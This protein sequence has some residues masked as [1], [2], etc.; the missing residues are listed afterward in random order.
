MPTAIVTGST[1]GIGLG[2]ARALAEA[3]CNIVLN[4]FGEAKAIESERAQ[5]EK[6]FKVRTIFDPTDLAK[7]AAI[8]QMVETTTR[9]FGKV[10]ILVN[11]GPRCGGLIVWVV[12]SVSWPCRFYGAKPMALR[13]STFTSL[14]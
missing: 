6:E 11:K 13:S 2:I 14:S 3:G 10:D 9:E 7:P 1:S 4:G 5:I 12:A 8:V